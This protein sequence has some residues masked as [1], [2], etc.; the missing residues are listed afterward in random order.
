MR[1]DGIQLARSTKRSSPA[2]ARELRFVERASWIPSLRIH[3]FLAAD[4]LS[5]A[6]IWMTAL[7]TLLALLYSW[8]VERLPRAFF[9]LFL[10]LETGLVGVFAAF[11]LF[12]FYVFWEVVLLPM[13]L[14]I[15]IWGGPRRVYAAVKFLLYTLVGSVLMLVAILYLYFAFSPH[16]FDLLALTS[17]APG[18]APGAAAWV[19][20]G[21][22]LCFAIKVPAVPLHTW[23][24]DA[25][26]EAPT[27][28]SMVLAGLL[29]KMGVYGFFRLLFPLVPAVATGHAGVWLVAGLGVAS[30][31]WGGLVAMAQADWKAL[32]AYSSVSALGYSLLGL[33][34]MTGA[35]LM[36]A[37]LQAVNHCVE[38]PLLFALVGV[39]Q[40]RAGHRDLRR[41]GGLAAQMP[42]F[43]ALA[44]VG[45]F[46]ALGLPG[47]NMFWGEALV[48]LGAYE[49]TSLLRAGDAR[50]GGVHA[51]WLVYVAL[52]AIVVT[53]AYVLWAVQRA[54]LGPPR[55]RALEMPDANGR[56]VLAI[57]P[58]CLLCI[59]LGVLPQIAIGFLGPS[60]TA[61]LETIRAGVPAGVR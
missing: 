2:E 41:M 7:V 56:E 44:F 59:L 61:L 60:V 25:H 53:A 5:I 15:G 27:G 4:G 14:L 58:L 26:V 47:L 50:A 46:A 23:L 49:P 32:V 38:S 39:V 17:L 20:A 33:A 51:T 54:L 3:Y 18:L 57:A 6:L 36:G 37:A 40:E 22:F 12:L 42:V 34:A 9:G 24:P 21:L 28:A 29:L 43:A 19:F 10:L 45:F 30:I 11:D 31:V 16:S 1:S 13:F 8:N 52:A 48:Y 35:G 55:E